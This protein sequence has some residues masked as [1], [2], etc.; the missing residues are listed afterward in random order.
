M[1]VCLC[2]RGINVNFH[3]VEYGLFEIHGMTRALLHQ[4]PLTQLVMP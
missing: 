4:L 1:Y 2:E 3:I